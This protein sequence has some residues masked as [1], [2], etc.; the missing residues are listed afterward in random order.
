MIPNNSIKYYW[1]WKVCLWMHLREHVDFMLYTWVGGQM[2]QLVLMS[3]LHKNWGY[4]HPL[5]S[6]FINGYTHMDDTGQCGRQG[7]IWTIKI[8]LEKFICLQT[9]LDV[10]GEHR[11]LVYKVI[12]FLQSHM[13]TWE[14]LYLHYIRNDVMHFDVS[15]SSAHKIRSGT[16]SLTT[17]ILC[18]IVLK[19]M[20]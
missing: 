10:V 20:F 4:G 5:S 14:T 7:G 8:S 13:Y 11:F 1:L 12:K 15:H 9:V 17:L 2:C 19:Y 16:M 18:Q 6:R 3:Y